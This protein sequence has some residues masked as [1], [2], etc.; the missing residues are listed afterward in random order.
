MKKTDNHEFT[1]NDILICPSCKTMFCP[2]TCPLILKNSRKKCKEFIIVVPHKCIISQSF[3]RGCD[4]NSFAIAKLLHKNLAINGI[5]VYPLIL[6]NTRPR[7]I[8]DANRENCPNNQIIKQLENIMVE[9]PNKYCIIEVHT[10]GIQAL[11]RK[12]AS[13][14][15][16][17]LNIRKS[18]FERNVADAMGILTVEGSPT[19]NHIG[20]TATKMGWNHVLIEFNET[21]TRK[22]L[23]GLSN[24]LSKAFS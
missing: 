18:I 12:L 24:K 2:E 17:V 4:K 15:A 14:L 6:Q 1:I 13:E 23:I 10:Y 20:F 7:K 9:N 3:D 22:Q 5:P 11:E 8:C 16:F 21:I 19:I